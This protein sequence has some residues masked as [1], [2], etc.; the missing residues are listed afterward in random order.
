MGFCLGSI[1]WIVEPDLGWT[2]DSIY[3][4]SYGP[5]RGLMSDPPLLGLQARSVGYCRGGMNYG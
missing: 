5:T 3:G 1:L 2:W 4:S